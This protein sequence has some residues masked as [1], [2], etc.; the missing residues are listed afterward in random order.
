MRGNRNS[1]RKAPGLAQAGRGVEEESSMQ[2]ILPGTGQD[3]VGSD[4]QSTA[5]ST[6]YST[7]QSTAYSTA[8]STA[9]AIGERTAQSIAQSTAQKFCTPYLGSRDSERP[10]RR[11]Q[12]SG[13]GPW[14]PEGARFIV[15]CKRI[16]T[17]PCL[18]HPHPHPHPHPRPGPGPGSQ[19]QQPPDPV[20]YLFLLP[21]YHSLWCAPL[22][23]YQRPVQVPPRASPSPSP[24]F[25]ACP[26]TP[27]LPPPLP[28]PPP[29]SSSP[30]SSSS[31]TPSPSSSSSSPSHQP[32]SPCPRLPLPPLRSGKGR[33]LLYRKHSSAFFPG[34]AQ[35]GKHRHENGTHFYS[36]RLTATSV[37]LTCTHPPS[38]VL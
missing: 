1:V 16:I 30:S 2:E 27:L 31:S 12:H 26:Q 36:V 38:L 17:H 25:P 5:Q 24:V 7:A 23:L 28:P 32:P 18:P 6:A 15:K 29:P 19:R 14:D 37:K 34:P 22:C 10:A 13:V 9:Q 21:P 11:H 33:C 20:Q 35:P 3:A 4:A 8:P